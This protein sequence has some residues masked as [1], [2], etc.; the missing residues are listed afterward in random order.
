MKK[1]REKAADVFLKY[2]GSKKCIVMTIEP[3]SKQ[4]L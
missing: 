3:R 4:V 1:I 2:T